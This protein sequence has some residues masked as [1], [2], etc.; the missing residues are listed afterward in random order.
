MHSLKEIKLEV[1]YKFLRY[2]KRSP[3]IG[4]FFKKSETYDIDVFID[5]DWTG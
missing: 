2:L 1:I 3:I 5:A 4:L